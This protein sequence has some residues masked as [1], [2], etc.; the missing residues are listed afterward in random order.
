VGLSAER[1]I[2]VVTSSRLRTQQVA[3]HEEV[4]VVL[5]RILRSSRMRGCAPPRP[6]RGPHDTHV[7]QQ[8]EAQLVPLLR[9]HDPC[10][11]G[12]CRRG[13]RLPTRHCRRTRSGLARG[14]IL[15]TGSAR[16]PRHSSTSAWPGGWRRCRPVVGRSRDRRPRARSPCAPDPQIGRD[17]AAG[18]SERS[19]RPGRL[20]GDVDPQAAA[21]R[22]LVVG[23]G[24]M[25]TKSEM[26]WHRATRVIEAS[27]SLEVDRAGDHVRAVQARR[28]ECAPAWKRVAVGPAAG[29]RPRAAEPR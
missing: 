13:F 7:V 25:R 14:Y 1:T 24:L 16:P 9:D 19:A 28:C 27:A 29:S 5:V 26:V 8:S 21:G 23:K 6:A 3:R 10:S 2:Q 4:G 22:S 11:V 15:G 18:G 12:V 20:I 17:A